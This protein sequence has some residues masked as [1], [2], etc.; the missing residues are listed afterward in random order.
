[1]PYVDTREA[2][3]QSAALS[4]DGETFYTYA[5]N[6][7]T[8]WSLNPV[9]VL[10]SIKI[11][12]PDFRIQAG[13]MIYVS[14]NK[15]VIFVK[16]K[17]AM[18]AFD[19][20]SKKWINKVFIPF[21]QAV[22]LDKSIV[23][24]MADRTIIKRDL[25]TLK[26]LKKVRFSN[27]LYDCEGCHDLFY[28]LFKNV[29]NDNEFIILTG[30]RLVKFN[31]ELNIIHEVEFD[32]L[33]NSAGHCYISNDYHLVAGDGGTLSLD[34]FKSVSITFEEVK[35]NKIPCFLRADSYSSSNKFILLQ[36]KEG[37]TIYSKNNKNTI[38]NIYRFSNDNWLTISPDGYFD[39]SDE[40][41]KYLY[42]KT[43]SGQSIPIDDATY[44]KFHKLINLKD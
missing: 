29:L 10:E 2:V 7:L 22:V 39:S 27:K 3:A 21:K 31:N 14:D 30:N 17:K 20:V 42:I 43:S 19:I 34:T 38:L 11:E 23:I 41:R 1:M 25:A 44:N 13:M 12:D 8:H 5:N 18:G 15:T 37:N 24:V 33:K 28:Y 6:T 9:K 35:A 36:N 32:L 40:A 26:E 4:P 16:Y